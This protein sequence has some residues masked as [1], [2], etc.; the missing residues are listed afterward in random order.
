MWIT[1]D[2]AVVMFARY[3]RARLGKSASHRVRAKA[4]VLETRGDIEGHKIWTRVADELD[5]RAKSP[6]SARN[7]AGGRR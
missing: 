7:E 3:C 5:E 4:K 6:S 2:E 1:Q